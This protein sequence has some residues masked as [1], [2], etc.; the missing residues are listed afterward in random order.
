MLWLRIP[1]FVIFIPNIDFNSFQNF[2]GNLQEGQVLLTLL[3]DGNCIFLYGKVVNFSIL[4]GWLFHHDY[5]ATA[6]YV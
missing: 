5:C 3:Y 6:Y 4:T 2:F 1:F